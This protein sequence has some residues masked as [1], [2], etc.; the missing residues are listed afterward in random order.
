MEVS[1]LQRGITDEF[2]EARWICH[3]QTLK[4]LNTD[5]NH[6]A[7]DMYCMYSRVVQNTTVLERF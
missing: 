2:L 6:Y 7:K 4:D 3:L 5:F 1:I